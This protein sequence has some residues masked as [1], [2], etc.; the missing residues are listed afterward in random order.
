MIYIIHLTALYSLRRVLRLL[1]QSGY[2]QHR[3][4]SQGQQE[5]R[6]AGG[7]PGHLLALHNALAGAHC[8]P[9][10][11]QEK[12]RDQDQRLEWN[13]SLMS[14]VPTYYLYHSLVSLPISYL[15]FPQVWQIT[16][17]L[18]AKPPATLLA[19]QGGS[20]TIRYNPIHQFY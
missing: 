9:P 8:V 14:G 19:P 15:Y 4:H 2:L 16:L 5:Q 7:Q 10:G 6:S 17:R 11:C 1:V 20:L 18:E 12:D 3:L 13:H